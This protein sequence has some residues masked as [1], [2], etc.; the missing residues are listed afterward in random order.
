V[1]KMGRTSARCV[2]ESLFAVSTQDVHNSGTEL[3]ESVEEPCELAMR[4]TRARTATSLEI[5][6]GESRGIHRR[7]VGITGNAY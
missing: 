3:R 2:C 4:S 5:G 7:R 6:G 1:P